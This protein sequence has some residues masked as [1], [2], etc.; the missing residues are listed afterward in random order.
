MAAT[1][2]VK[3]LARE[4]AMPEPT[5]RFYRDR[6]SD[7]IPSSGEGRRRRYTDEALALL[8]EAR[9][10]V[11]GEGLT[12][13]EVAERWRPTKA[14]NAET[15][16]AAAVGQQGSMAVAPGLEA[17]VVAIT[18]EQA[19]TRQALTA[20]LAEVA[21]AVR[22]GGQVAQ[23]RDEARNRAEGLQGTIEVLKAALGESRVL[24]EQATAERDRLAAELDTERKL[25]WW[26]RLIGKQ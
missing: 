20:G 16:M 24:L 4:L 22:G 19:A 23:D 15:A 11:R 5:V 14:V 6:L 18:Q 3:Q 10:L 8:R 12:L 26:Q 13:D 25:K 21:E 1:Y 9:D 7:F 2:T 17:I